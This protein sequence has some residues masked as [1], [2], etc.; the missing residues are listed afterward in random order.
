MTHLM[1]REWARQKAVAGV[2]SPL[3]ARVDLHAPPTLRDPA[4][5]K[6]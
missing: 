5:T 4:S 6:P 2:R 3:T 1:K